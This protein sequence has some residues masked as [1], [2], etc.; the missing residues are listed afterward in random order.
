[1]GWWLRRRWRAC[2]IARLCTKGPPSTLHQAE[3]T[4]ASTN[5]KEEAAKTTATGFIFDSWMRGEDDFLPVL[6]FFC[7]CFCFCFGLFWLQAEERGKWDVSSAGT[8]EPGDEDLRLYIC[9]D[10]KAVICNMKKQTNKHRHLCGPGWR[11]EMLG[12]R[13]SGRCFHRSHTGR[14]FHSPG[15]NQNSRSTGQ[16]PE[17]GSG[18]LMAE[19]AR[20]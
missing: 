9:H 7:F 14:A 13:Q 11:N 18:C 5:G 15:T 16:I 2:T 1:V 20:C 19:T 10:R 17:H 3:G 12:P 6:L 8:F 4:L